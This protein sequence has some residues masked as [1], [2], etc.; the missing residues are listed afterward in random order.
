MMGVQEALATITPDQ[1]LAEYR[2]LLIS[3][4]KDPDRIPATR[5]QAAAALER[6]KADL[7]VDV[8]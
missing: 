2:N 7:L 6:V 8:R 3:W 5:D 4:G 1:I